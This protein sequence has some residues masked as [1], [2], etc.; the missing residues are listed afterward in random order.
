MKVASVISF[1]CWGLKFDFM[2]TVCALTLWKTFHISRKKVPSSS[3]SD[4]TEASTAKLFVEMELVTSLERVWASSL[5]IVW[6]SSLER[7][8]ASSLEKYGPFCRM[9]MFF[10]LLR[11]EYGLLLLSLPWTGFDSVKTAISLSLLLVMVYSPKVISIQVLK[12][13]YI[14]LHI[15]T[16]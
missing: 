6:T 7:V 4:E 11:K 10:F 3:D 5:E 12:P 15:S 9:S 16:H 1:A 13:E 14:L 2:S 8:W